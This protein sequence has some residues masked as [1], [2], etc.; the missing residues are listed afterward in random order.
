[1]ASLL[2]R[3][4]RE[5]LVDQGRQFRRVAGIKTSG[6]GR[7]TNVRF[8]WA[9]RF[10]ASQ[11]VPQDAFNGDPFK[12]GELHVVVLPGT[13]VQARLQADVLQEALSVQ[14][15]ADSDARQKQSAMRATNHLQA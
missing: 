10:I 2:G 4:T 5:Q 6:Y 15:V 1:M 8:L 7:G 14:L 12:R 9:S 11:T 13:G 3:R